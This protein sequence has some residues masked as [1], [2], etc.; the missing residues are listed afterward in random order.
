MVARMLGTVLLWLL[1]L[2]AAYAL[3]VPLFVNYSVMQHLLIQHVFTGPQH[4]AVLR[5][6]DVGCA[7]VHFTEP[8][9]SGVTDL[10]K[11]RAKVAADFG[12]PSQGGQCVGLKH[13]SGSAEVQGKPLIQ[14]AERLAIKF[15]VVNVVLA[16]A[17]GQSVSS[18]LIKAALDSQLQPYVDKLSWDLKPQLK[19]LA[20]RP[21]LSLLGYSA[22]QVEQLI[23][24]FRLGD[25]HVRSDGLAA[26]VQ[27]SLDEQGL[28]GF[29][30]K[31]R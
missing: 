20:S 16:D 7:T 17:G 29:L 25:I 10:L 9:L 1:S 18:G 30:P 24:R 21:P 12:M 28:L 22:Q 31:R 13:W 4:S 11:V 2:S 8:Q 19:Q 3:N 26:V 14:G 6:N 27:T 23:A 5:L 15:A